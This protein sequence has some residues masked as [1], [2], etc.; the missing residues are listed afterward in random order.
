MVVVTV[1]YTDMPNTGN[2]AYNGGTSVV[3]QVLA[4]AKAFAQIESSVPDSYGLVAD[5]ALCR[6]YNSGVMVEAWLNGVNVT[7]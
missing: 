6:V 3:F 1:Q 2:S 5:A 7:G 4:E